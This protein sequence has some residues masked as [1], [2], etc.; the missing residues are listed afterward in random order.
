MYSTQKDPILDKFLRS[1]RTRFRETKLISRQDGIK[2]VIRALKARLPLFFLPDMDFGPKDAI[3]VPFFGV[4]AATIDAVPR[5]A[6]LT[7]AKV[8]PVTIRQFGPNEPYKIKFFPS[9]ENYPSANLL[10]DTKTMNK[11]IEEQT[12]SMPEQYYWVHKRFK[13]RPSGDAKLYD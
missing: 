13:T 12:L 9:W 3:F 8:V 10:A 5:L 4:S 2:G 11:F 7:K 1:R 6:A